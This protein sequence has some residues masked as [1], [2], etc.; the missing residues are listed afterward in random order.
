MARKTFIAY[1]YSEA[2]NLRDKIIEKLGD[3]SRYYQGETAASPDMS[4]QKIDRIKESLKNMIFQ[5][6]VTIV[7]ISPNLKD[8]DWVDWE[9]QYSLKEYKRQSKT[10]KTNGVVG[11]IMK[12]NGGYDWL[13]SRTQN[14]DGCVSRCI[15][16]SK[17]YGII[18]NNRFNLNTDNKYSCPTCKSYDQLKGSYISLIDE[19]RFLNNPAW[20]IENAYD[21]SKETENYILSKQ[22]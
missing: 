2:V 17:L 4:G 7:I 5:T 20:F 18:Q 9:I 22:R 3:D 14:S 13:V 16:D 6:S 11:V 21:K 12:Y 19:E 15:D 10:S 1:K 8:S